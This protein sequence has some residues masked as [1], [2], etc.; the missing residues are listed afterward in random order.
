MKNSS[1]T[2]DFR[3]LQQYQK[4]Q[5]CKSKDKSEKYLFKLSL[6]VEYGV[7]SGLPE[8]VGNSRSHVMVAKGQSI[9]SQHTS[10][11]HGITR[12]WGG[13][14][15]CAGSHNSAAGPRTICHPLSRHGRHRPSTFREVLSS[16]GN[17]VVAQVHWSWCGVGSVEGLDVLHGECL[18]SWSSWTPSA[19]SSAVGTAVSHARRTGKARGT[20]RSLITGSAGISSP[21]MV[22]I[23][24]ANGAGAA[25]HVLVGGALEFY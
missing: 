4:R 1:Q 16:H 5:I 20:A 8:R 22:R 6:K 11:Q 18:A 25:V 21:T 14:V 2:G 7:V 10:R 15:G 24:S 12:H 13:D 19:A 3:L 17:F 23:P 9:T